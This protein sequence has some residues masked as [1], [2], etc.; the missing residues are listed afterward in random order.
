MFPSL[1]GTSAKKTGSSVF[2]LPCT[3]LP[4]TSVQS[5]KRK[6]QFGGA[7]ITMLMNHWFK[8]DKNPNNARGREMGERQNK[9]KHNLHCECLTTITVNVNV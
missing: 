2:V 5:P 7:L 3:F 9:I 4:I 6:M 1:V 8:N